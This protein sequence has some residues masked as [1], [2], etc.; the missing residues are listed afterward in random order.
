MLFYHFQRLLKLP[1]CRKSVI[2]KKPRSCTSQ[3][4]GELFGRGMLLVGAAEG[5]QSLVSLDGGRREA[6]VF[7]P[8]GQ[9]GCHRE[10]GGDQGLHLGV[11]DG[12]DGVAGG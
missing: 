7:P 1:I 5:S 6:V 8:G 3:E 2:I 12:E 11:L 10:A 4:R 9:T